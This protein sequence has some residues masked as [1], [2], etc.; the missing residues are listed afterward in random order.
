MEEV[1]SL[2]SETLEMFHSLN[3]C[4]VTAEHIFHVTSFATFRGCGCNLIELNDRSDEQLSTASTLLNKLSE[5][6]NED[7]NECQELATIKHLVQSASQALSCHLGLNLLALGKPKSALPKLRMYVEDNINDGKA[8]QSSLLDVSALQAYSRALLGCGLSATEAQD[9]F[10]SSF[11]LMRNILGPTEAALAIARCQDD[12]GDCFC[13]AGLLDAAENILLASK[14]AKVAKLGIRSPLVADTESL[15]G[16]VALSRGNEEGLSAAVSHLSDCQQTRVVYFG[17]THAS[18]ASVLLQLGTVQSAR[19]DWDASLG[20]LHE[21]K[22]ILEDVFGKGS[23]HVAH[24]E[25]LMG[26]G[27]L[28]KLQAA[29]ATAMSAAAAGRP[30]AYLAAHIDLIP[31][32]AISDSTITEWWRKSMEE[33]EVDAL[34]TVM[35][36]AEEDVR[37][38]LETLEKG[39]ASAKDQSQAIAVLSGLLLE[40]GRPEDAEPYARH[41]LESLKNHGLMWF[42]MGMDGIISANRLKSEALCNLIRVR[43]SLKQTVLL[44]LLLWELLSCDQ[45]VYAKISE[46]IG[47]TKELLALTLME[48]K[49][50]DEAITWMKRSLRIK[51]GLYGETSLKL[52]PCLRFLANELLELGLLQEAE[53][54]FRNVHAIVEAQLG[55]NHPETIKELHNLGMVTIKQ[56]KFKDAEPI[57][58]AIIEA[59]TSRYGTTSSRVVA[60]MHILA[61]VQYNSGQLDH[62]EHTLK[63]ALQLREVLMGTQHQEIAETLMLLSALLNDQSKYSEAITLL[64]RALCILRESDDMMQIA[65]CLE[66]RVLL[67]FVPLL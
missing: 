7:N 2:P 65:S 47:Q 13:K 15:L 40:M 35:Y 37:R 1:K 16:Q 17:P 33:E 20:L 43:R 36:I 61:K 54:Q 31:R 53:E 28:G 25:V 55:S 38:A 63:R 60:E 41:R 58:T 39:G 49:K 9:M 67:L 32:F 23:L 66:V 12:L 18:V 19:E 57:Y 46:E 44:E 56:N 29:R 10:E 4:V 6:F 51:V 48:N 42:G 8:G 34:E 45:E 22:S 59:D 21:G 11:S 3:Q 14:K 62:A 24:A 27:V 52:V 30:P 50:H 64:E 26:R 5:V